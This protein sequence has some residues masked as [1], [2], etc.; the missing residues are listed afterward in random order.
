MET[1]LICEICG[2]EF[3]MHPCAPKPP[4]SCYK[5]ECRKLFFRKYSKDY[6]ATYVD[7]N[8]RKTL[9]K[10]ILK[11]YGITLN[12][13]ERIFDSQNK[14]CAICKSKDSGKKGWN[15]DHDHVTN[16]IRGILC[17][18]CNLGLG[19]FKDN[20]EFLKNAAEYLAN[21]K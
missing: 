5:Q 13:K 12:E 11:R 10:K 3:E 15:I 1:K 6:K 9:S 7:K 4:R 8:P 21:S 18:S 2:N 16:K 20:K 14:T 19:H 17:H